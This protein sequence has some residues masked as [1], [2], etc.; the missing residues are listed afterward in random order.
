MFNK[1]YQSVTRASNLEGCSQVKLNSRLRDE[2]LR[3]G[4]LNNQITLKYE[5]M[6]ILEK[7]LEKQNAEN[8]ELWECK[9]FGSFSENLS[10]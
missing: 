2:N 7:D 10:I 4:S 1:T 9:M 6:K 8:N 5:Q 3:I